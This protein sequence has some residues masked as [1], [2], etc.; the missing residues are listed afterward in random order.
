MLRSKHRALAADPHNLTP[1]LD[2]ARGDLSRGRALGDP[3][4]LGRA[5]AALS[6]WLPDA[7]P[8]EV[9]L[10]SAVIK[11]SN[12]DFTGALADLAEVLRQLARLARAARIDVHAG[13]VTFSPIAHPTTPAISRRRTIDTGSANQII[14]MTTV[15]VAP[16]PVQI[17]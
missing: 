10:L 8:P 9:T 1:A 3:R 2:V 7:A 4:Y 11:Q 15:P 17:A 12:H 16:T 13:D 6:P 5:E 14:P